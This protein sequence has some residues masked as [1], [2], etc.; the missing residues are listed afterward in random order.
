MKTVVGLYDRFEDAQQAVQALHDSGFSKEDISL[1]ARDATGEFSRHLEG[2]QEGETRDVSE[3]AA[4]GAGIG[5]V[6]GGLGGLLLGLGALAIPGIGPVIA[7]GPIVSTLAGAGIGAVAGGLVGSLVDLGIPEEHAEYYSEGVRRGGTLLVVRSN[8]ERADM[9]ADIMNR[10]APVDVEERAGMWRKEDWKGYDP[11]AQPLTSDQME[12]NR[13]RYG[14]NI[15]VTGSS[16]FTDTESSMR[17]HDLLDT[18]IQDSGLS[19]YGRSQVS[20]ETNIPVTGSEFSRQDE[21]MLDDDLI[22]R[23][24]LHTDTNIPVTGS[25]SWDKDRDM[26]DQDILDPDLEKDVNIPVTGSDVTLP[27]IE[28]DIDIGKHEVDKGNVRASAHIT[29]EP[30][31]KD[32]NLRQEHI[33][34]ERRPVDRPATDSD[35]EFEDKTYEFKEKGEEPMVHKSSHV[36]EEVHINKDVDEEKFTV[37]DS[38]RRQDVEVERT[39]FT[40]DF[41]DSRFRSHYMTN[42]SSSGYPYDY[43][44]PAY[45]FGYEMRQDP[46]YRDYDWD[47]FEMEGRHEWEHRGHKSTWDQIKDAVKHAWNDI[48][49]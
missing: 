2:T 21:G 6:L 15:P 37:Q 49:Y 16:H 45:R 9:V 47:R 11:N 34:V 3:G 1:I 14:D 33:N 32:I 7:A 48:R 22:E 4:T 43:Y 26:M 41:D 24:R 20:S 8:D 31:E 46:R 25:E 13:Q 12:F 19:D 30:V 44:Q 18:D 36:V 42:Y 23:D 10:F 29:E 17:D 38:V 40:G 28:E 39:D 27:V 5:A 35:Y